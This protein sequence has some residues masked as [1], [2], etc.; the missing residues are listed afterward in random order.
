M[1]DIGDNNSFL[2][3]SQRPGPN[4]FVMLGTRQLSEWTG[5]ATAWLKYG[6]E[7]DVKLQFNIAMMFILCYNEDKSFCLKISV[8][9]CDRYEEL[10]VVIRSFAPFRGMKAYVR[11]KILEHGVLFISSSQVFIRKW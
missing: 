4:N 9:L 7:F 5:A 1:P 6:E 8:D 3:S 11:A 10:I 2:I